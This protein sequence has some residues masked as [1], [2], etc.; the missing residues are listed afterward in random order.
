MYVPAHFEETNI[1][2]MQRLIAEHPLGT[3]VQLGPS[4]L[5]ANH[6]PFLVDNRNGGYGT[7]VGHVAR[8]NAAWH[9]PD[10]AIDALVVF[11]GPSAYVSPNWYVTKQETHQVV[12]TYNYAVVHAHG[13]VI[14]H[15]DPKWLRGIVGK[16]TKQFESRQAVPWKMA[17]A[18]KEF[19]TGQLEQIVGI[20]IPV[21]RMVGKW[22]TSQN[23]VP[24]DRRGAVEGLR[25]S[26]APEDAAM[27][28]LVLAT[29]SE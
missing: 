8:R 24:A 6:I 22:K 27:A 7:L 1:E 11:Q 5:V 9:L 12:P 16:L 4:G 29:L 10:D 20:E 15:E 19:I 18:P 28:E 23:R 25:A 17:D 3:L 26:G 2:V 14:I 21:S 13:P